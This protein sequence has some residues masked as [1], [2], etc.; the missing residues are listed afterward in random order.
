AVSADQ[1]VAVAIAKVHGDIF[2]KRLIAELHG[3]ICGRNHSALEVHLGRG[4]AYQKFEIGIGVL[5]RFVMILQIEVQTKKARC[6]LGTSSPVGA[7]WNPKRRLSIV[8]R[9][10]VENELEI[11]CHHHR[12]CYLR[13]RYN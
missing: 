2:E 5:Y 7:I 6:P 12:H 4:P 8:L 9:T 1:T 3:N 11:H 10:S 13:R